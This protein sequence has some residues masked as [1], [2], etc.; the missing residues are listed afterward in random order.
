MWTACKN[1][2][3]LNMFN[4]CLNDFFCTLRCYKVVSTKYK[5][6]CLWINNIF[7][8]ETSC[9]SF[10]KWFKNISLCIAVCCC[11]LIY[12]LINVHTRYCSAYAAIIFTDNEILWNV[13]K[14]SCKVT[15]IGCTKGCIWKTFTGTMSWNKVFQNIKTFTEVWLDWKFDSVTWCICHQTTHTCKLFNLLVRTTGTRIGHHEDVVIL[16]KTGKKSILKT[17]ISFLPYLDYILM[18]FFISR[19]T[20]V[21]V[22][23]NLFNFLFCIGNKFFLNRWHCHLW[24]RNCHC[25]SCRILITC[26]FNII[27]NFCCCSSSVCVNYML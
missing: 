7:C 5:L 3:Y 20:S 17:F 22:L 27:K 18:T 8:K 25:C 23:C 12:K 9:N 24:N 4:T 26:C 2:S 15:W 16:I 19:T 21:I 14:T 10:L 13:N 6:T 11:F 1:C